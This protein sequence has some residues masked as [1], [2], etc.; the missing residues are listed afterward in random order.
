MWAAV[1]II[2]FLERLSI[3]RPRRGRNYDWNRSSLPTQSRISRTSFFLFQS[4]DIGKILLNRPGHTVRKI[5]S[6]R[7]YCSFVLTIWQLLRW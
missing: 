5:A 7:A 3:R 1:I 4:V 6:V 2:F